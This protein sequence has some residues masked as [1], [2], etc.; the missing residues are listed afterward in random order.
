MLT[1]FRRFP[2]RTLAALATTLI[3]G[4]P[5]LAQ[6]DAEIDGYSPTD[7]TLGTVVT[8]TG[9]FA[10][11]DGSKIAKPKIFGTSGDTKAKVILKVMSNDATSITA[12]VKKIPSSK[13]APAAGTMWTLNVQPK[14]KGAFGATTSKDLMSVIAPEIQDVNPSSAMPGETITVSIDHAGSKPVKA[15]IGG[16][17]TKLKPVKINEE[18]DSKS[19]TAKVPKSL[20]NGSWDVM[21]TNKVGSDTA[22]GGLTVF[23]STKKLGKHIF[24]A[25]INGKGYKST[26]KFLAGAD[27]GLAVVVAANLKAN[28]PQRSFNIA[29]PFAI[30]DDMAPQ[31]YIGFPAT[32]LTFTYIETTLNGLIPTIVSWLPKTQNDISVTITGVSGGQVAGNFTGLLSSAGQ[33]DLNVDGQFVVDLK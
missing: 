30:A 14:G 15:T 1:T 4:G 5:A 23:G 11:D 24:T 18:S 19:F 6:D 27:G 20:G 13:K 25:T 33:P 21:I 29:I 10:N 12:E 31:K 16:K 22:T 26:G 32:L 3:L 9:T 2:A 28:N 7:I 17:K 8:I